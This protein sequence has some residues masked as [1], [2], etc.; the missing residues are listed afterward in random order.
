[1]SQPPRS[2]SSEPEASPDGSVTGEE[3]CELAMPISAPPGLELP[4]YEYQSSSTSEPEREHGSQVLSEESIA[5]PDMEHAREVA[6]AG[7]GLSG[8]VSVMIRRIPFKYTQN[9]LMGEL[10]S[11]GFRDTYDFFYLPLDHRHPGNRGFAFINFISPQ[12]AQEFYSKY[13]GQKFKHFDDGAALSVFPADVQGF[14]ETVNHYFAG[15]PKKKNQ[16]EPVILKP[17]TVCAGEDGGRCGQT[18]MH[19]SQS[20]TQKQNRKK[21]NKSAKFQVEAPYMPGPMGC[22]FG[23]PPPTMAPARFCGICGNPRIVGHNFCQ[24]CG[25]LFY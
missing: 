5:E 10:N 9:K 21:I 11:S 15:G 14:Q 25:G 18:S 16:G 13:H 3:R 6:G 4:N 17:L 22:Q 23:M 24:Y 2:E 8:H 19:D 12:W 20:T 1:M 7:G